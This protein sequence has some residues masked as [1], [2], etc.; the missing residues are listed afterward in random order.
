MLPKLSQ[1][2]L[3]RM[4][5]KRQEAKRH[6]AFLYEGWHCHDSARAAPTGKTRLTWDVLSLANSTHHRA[7]DC[8][9]KLRN[10]VDVSHL[11]PI[12]PIMHRLRHRPTTHTVSHQGGLD[13]CGV[14]IHLKDSFACLR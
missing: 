11:T 2:Q 6:A 3:L 8:P 4:A 12:F 13:V 9:V 5:R 7:F 10:S 1:R 14:I